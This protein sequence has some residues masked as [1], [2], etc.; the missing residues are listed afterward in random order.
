MLLQRR[1]WPHQLGL[2][3]G[4]NGVSFGRAKSLVALLRLRGVARY[5]QLT[6][7]DVGVIMGAGVREATGAN[8]LYG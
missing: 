4:S 3:L 5:D 2:W 7:P 1:S 8:A 6:C